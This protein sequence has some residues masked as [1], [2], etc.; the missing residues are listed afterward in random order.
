[1]VAGTGGTPTSGVSL[2]SR[3]LGSVFPS[4]KGQFLAVNKFPCNFSA[5]EDK[6]VI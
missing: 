2:S 1:M 4:R 6:D 3:S 5:E